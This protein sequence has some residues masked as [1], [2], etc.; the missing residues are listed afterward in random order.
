MVRPMFIISMIGLLQ[1][2]PVAFVD[3]Y[4]IW[5][6]EWGYEIKTLSIE[7]LVLAALIFSL[8]I[9]EYVLYRKQEPRFM[10]VG[11]MLQDQAAHGRKELKKS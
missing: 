6:I 2:V 3:A 9:Y 4:T 11:E 10:T 7:N 8:E 1:V 5:Q